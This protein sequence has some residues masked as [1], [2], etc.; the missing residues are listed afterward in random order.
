MVD[1]AQGDFAGGI[2]Y[3][4]A[5]PALIESIPDSKPHRHVDTTLV[6]ADKEGLLK[7]FL[8][9]LRSANTVAGYVKAY[10]ILPSTVWGLARNVFTEKG[11]QKVNSIQIPWII[12]TSVA[13][14]TP[15]L[16]GTGVSLWPHG[17][18][19]DSQFI[20]HY[21]SRPGSDFHLPSGRALLRVVRRD[22]L[23]KKPHTR[24]RGLLFYRKR[25]IHP[26][27]SLRRDCQVATRIG[28]S[29]QRR[30]S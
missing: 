29:R 4:D 22:H 12:S 20:V 21:Y 18:I 28:E 27:T 16:V 11:L 26:Q 23:R 3:S 1:D 14:G 15:V 30:A 8:N 24:T 6:K 9:T 7:L 2:I 17:H 25:R 5:D 13:R 10:I 19:E